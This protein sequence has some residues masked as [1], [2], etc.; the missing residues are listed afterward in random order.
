MMNDIFE[1]LG[2]REEEVRAYLSLLDSGPCAA[3]DL[4]KI[5]G[6]PRPTVYGYLERLMAGGLA[7]QSLRRGVKIF[8]PEPGEKIRLLYARKIEDL[9]SKEKALDDLLPTLEKR[10]GMALMRPRI[11]VF[12]GRE[13]LESALQDV[14]SHQSIKMLSFWSIKAAIEATSED[15][16]WYHNKERI[17][18][19]IQIDAIWPPEQAI[20]VKRYPALGAGPAFKREIRIAPQ[21]IESSMGYWIYAN[22]VLFASSRKESFCFIIESAELVQMMS[23]QHRVIWDLSTPLTPKAADMK[24]FLDD[25]HKDDS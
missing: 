14:L 12:E 18:R 9:R 8:V 7:T 23:N 11:Q 6:L 17:K 10:T 21:G 13:G 25:L 2:F 15:F 24:P 20:D 22:K 16:F 1:T 3:G 5:M 19:G 4:A